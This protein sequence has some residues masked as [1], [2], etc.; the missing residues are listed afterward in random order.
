MTMKPARRV[1]ALFFAA[2]LLL[3]ACAPLAGGRASGGE[4]LTWETWG[5]Y[6]RHKVFLDLL[7]QTC[8]DI[9]LEFR[10]Y[11]GGNRTGY[12]WAQMR[13]GDIPDI[14]ITSQILDKD[15]AKERL[16]DLSGYDFVNRFSTAILDR[17][18]IDGGV[19]LLPVDSAMYGIF[20]N[21]TLLEEKGW[22]VPTNF[23]EL[24]AL[25]GEIEAEG[26]IPGVIGTQLTGGP[27]SSVFNLAKTSWLTTPEGVK[28]EREFLAGTATAKGVWEDTMDY[29]QRYIDIGMFH[30]DPEDRSSPR[31][32]L[33]YLGGR[34]AVFC[35]AVQ[36]VN[37]TA[38]PET[39]DQLGLMP[40]ISENGS[41]NLYMYNPTCYFGISKRLTEPGNEKKLEN[42]IR[43]LSLLFS[44][45]G[46][47]AF[48]TEE[49]PCVMSVLDSAVIPEGNLIH[50]AQ[51]ALWEGRAFPMTYVRWENVLSE[52]GQ[53]Y[54][55]WFRGEN[56]MD[57]PGCIARMDALQRNY[58]E[59]SDQLSF[60]ESTEDFTLEETAELIGRALGSAVGAGAAIIPLGE[61]HE[62]GVE[63]P[64]S[65]TGKL[66][67]GKINV[68]IVRSIVPAFDGEYALLSMTGAQAGELAAAGFDA[69]GDGHPFPYVLVT[70][71]GAPLEDE[72]TYQVA[73]LA[74]GYSEEAGRTY[75]AQVC[76]GSLAGFLRSYLERRGTVSP[77]ERAWE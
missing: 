11:T 22:K 53:A 67:A 17:V 76:E 23:E 54:K 20:Y 12:S 4:A 39:G 36:T 43:I 57:G 77:E 42:A 52:M 2:A 73:F 47:A 30:A 37:I 64:S 5:S 27:F 33:D 25:C 49:T 24:E 72:K 46:Q 14:F 48:I 26:L 69:E 9:E 59:H 6:S 7:A 10:S 38:F 60:C 63:L 8:P 74:R 66:Y 29:V 61:F 75:G 34:R 3:S 45:E 51:Q 65:V 28:W 62:G 50:D 68:E 44:P 41:K 16:A 55:E 13:A 19:Y 40:F 31:L 70:R 15:L 71:D 32:I 58:L 18:A 21:K 35:T 1:L 56:G